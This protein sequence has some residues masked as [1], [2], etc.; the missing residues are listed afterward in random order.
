[1]KKKVSIIIVTYNSTKHIYD[2]LESIFKHNDLGDMLE[3]I[4]V[5]NDSQEQKTMFEGI[6]AKYSEKVFLI[7]SGK[8]GGYGFGNNIGIKKA[9][10]PIVI[11][12][13]PDVRLVQ[14][15][16]KKIANQFSSADVGMIG[17]DFVDGSCPYYFKRGHSSILRSLFFKFYVWRKHYNAEEMYMSGS[18]LAFNKECFEKAGWFDENIFMYSEE[19]DITNRMLQQ[20]YKVEWCPQIKVLHMAHDRD[21]NPFLDRIRLE[22]GAYYERKYNVDSRKSYNNTVLVLRMKILVASLFFQKRQKNKF[23]KYLYNLRSFCNE[24]N[25]LIAKE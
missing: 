19:A 5:D 6:A 24:Q 25:A 14:P 13:N 17:V 15:I 21:F 7:N 4:I 10:S 23:L 11:V 9:T 2:C 8:N 22:S 1:M 12:M 20:G 16:F 3:V 18:F